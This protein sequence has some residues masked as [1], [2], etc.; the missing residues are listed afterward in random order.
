MRQINWN[1]RQVKWD[2]TVVLDF[3]PDFLVGSPVF[4]EQVKDRNAAH[5]C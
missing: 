5:R 2:R 1:L 3:L 4:A